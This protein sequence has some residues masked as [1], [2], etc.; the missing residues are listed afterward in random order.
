MQFREVM[1]NDSGQV[2]VK[3][4]KGIQQRTLTGDVT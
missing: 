1:Q 3:Q 2:S 4:K